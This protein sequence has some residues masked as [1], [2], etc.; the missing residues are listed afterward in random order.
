MA[1]HD[2]DREPSGISE[3]PFS[4]NDATIISQTPPLT[5]RPN[6]EF[7]HPRELGQA[8]EG[9]QLDHFK[10]VEFIGGGGMGAVFRAHD[11]KLDRTV[12]VK[13]LAAGQA[14]DADT[15]LRFRN[16]AQSA[17][18][19]DHINIARVYC[20]GEDH[21]V[22]YIVFEYIDGVN[23]RDLVR[24]QGPLALGEALSYILQ[25][26]EALAHAW[27]R[28]VVH[29]DI[30]PSNI[31]INGHGQ[32]KL[33]DM[34][35]ARMQHIGKVG[36]ELTASGVTLG[37]FDYISPEQAREPRDADTRSDIYSLGCTLYFMLCGSPPFA[38]GTVL[39]KLLKHQSDPVP[40]PRQ[41]RPDLPAE[42]S[43]LI[44]KMLAKSPE[45]R[46]QTPAEL[47]AAI[48]ALSEQTGLVLSRPLMTVPL[49]LD[50]SKNTFLRQ[51]VPWIVP[52]AV[53]VTCVGLL[54]ILEQRAVS[55]ISDSIVSRPADTLPETGQRS[56]RGGKISPESSVDLSELDRLNAS[57]A[58][59][60]GLPPEPSE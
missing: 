34:G 21:G 51:H 49:I 33:V 59:S 3:E 24:S 44:A 42:I 39:Q 2:E 5:P 28:E 7:L 25:I 58:I 9:H 19:L 13:V 26:A 54:G 10:L 43:S 53:L 35:L 48:L 30:K 6:I 47:M 60:A 31:L 23:L 18:R 56:P 38:E 27:Q 52:I 32:A 37:T 17:A 11:T 45:E 14:D 4:E 41:K 46:H 12:A 1:I 29:R 57:N 40:D 50:T 55:P 16:E 36:D 22:H 20:V 15:L 8:L